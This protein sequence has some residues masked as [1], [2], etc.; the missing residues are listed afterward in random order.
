MDPYQKYKSVNYAILIPY[1]SK[2]HWH[3]CESGP[4][5]LKACA[6]EDGQRQKRIVN[7]RYQS[8]CAMSSQ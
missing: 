4:C 6:C 5:S 1:S 3:N 7:K 8:T 2:I